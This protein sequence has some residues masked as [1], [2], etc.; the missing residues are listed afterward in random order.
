LVQY[1]VALKRCR[2][3]NFDW[4]NID[5]DTGNPTAAGEYSLADKNYGT[6]VIW[7][8]DQQFQHVD[9]SLR[10]NIIAFYGHQDKPRDPGEESRRGIKVE[11]AVER[12]DH[13][14][15]VSAN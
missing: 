15:F 2:S 3:G 7:L 1:K 13:S 12:M 11:K 10:Q 6:L 4:P 14:K 5:Y 8:K 9:N